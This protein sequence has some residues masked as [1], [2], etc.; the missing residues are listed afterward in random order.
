[1]EM[2][3]KDSAIQLKNIVNKIENLESEKDVL[4]VYINEILQ[5]AKSKGFN[6]KILKMILKMRKLKFTELQ[7]QE[8]LLDV[9]KK[10]LGMVKDD[11]QN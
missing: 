10:A 9:Y 4:T 2:I 1:M 5:D 6:T 11:V 8:D 7:E 3:D